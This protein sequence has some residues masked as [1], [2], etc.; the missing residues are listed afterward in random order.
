MS[1][2]STLNEVCE[3]ILQYRSFVIVSHT[4]PDADAF[5]SACGLS[6]ALEELGNKVINL[7]EHGAVDKFSGIPGVSKVVS[8]PP[9]HSDNTLVIVCDCGALERVG[10]GLVPWI[11]AAP[12]TLNIDHHY[13]NTLFGSV[14]YVDA[15]ASSTAEIIYDVIKILKS[16]LSRQGLPS[17]ECA[18]ALFAGVMSDTGGFK[19][20]STTPK[21]FLTAHDLV[22][23][24]AKPNEISQSLFSN[25]SLGAV[26]LQA[27][28]M[29][30]LQVMFDNKCAVITVTQEMLKRHSADLLDTDVLA[31]RARDIKGVQVAALLKQDVDLWRVSLRSKNQQ[32]DVSLV[33]ADFGGG[34]HRMAAAFRW[35]RSREELED[36]LFARLADLF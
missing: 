7:N 16:K 2:N 3:L 32:Y 20:A 14:N 19:Y 5:G 28:A 34:G 29:L 12:K 33:A 36:K 11:K 17:K 30:G 13:S 22:M 9:E 8:S 15:D 18:S 27:E 24:G 4:S 25:S 31:E 26:K 23:A 10:D 6:M 1:V 35:R 21:T